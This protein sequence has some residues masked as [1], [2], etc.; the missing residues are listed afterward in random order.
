MTKSGTGDR[1]NWHFPGGIL[2][3][4]EHPKGHQ[5]LSSL[6]KLGT[7]WRRTVALQKVLTASPRAILEGRRDVAMAWEASSISPL[8]DEVSP[9]SS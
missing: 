7:C 9:K 1:A 6:E 8:L 3:A 2:R 5:A 4:Q